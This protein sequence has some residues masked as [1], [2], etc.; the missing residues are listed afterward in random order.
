M[1][2]AVA[3]TRVECSGCG[4]GTLAHPSYPLPSLSTYVAAFHHSS[5]VQQQHLMMGGLTIAAPACRCAGALPRRHFSLRQ[6]RR[7]HQAREWRPGG[8]VG[9]RAGRGRHADSD[10]GHGR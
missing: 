4:I 7:R 5:I 6:R 1:A 10:A 3:C 8:S 2:Q 9:L